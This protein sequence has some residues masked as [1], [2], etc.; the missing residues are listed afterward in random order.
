MLDA[1]FVYKFHD[2]AFVHYAAAHWCCSLVA[3]L[4]GAVPN[5]TLTTWLLLYL[6]S[7]S[8]Y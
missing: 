5:K 8:I 7:Y 4:L 2:N 6:Y 3:V 1:C